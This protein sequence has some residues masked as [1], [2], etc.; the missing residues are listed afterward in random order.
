MFVLDSAQPAPRD[1]APPGSP[2][3]YE[4]D[5][6]SARELCLPAPPRSPSFLTFLCWCGLGDTYG[7]LYPPAPSSGL[8]PNTVLPML[9]KLSQ[10]RPLEGLLVGSCVALRAR[11]WH[12]PTLG[13]HEMP[14]ALRYIS[15]PFWKG[16]GLLG[17]RPAFETTVWLPGVAA[18]T[19]LSLHPG[20]LSRQ[21][22]GVHGSAR[23]RL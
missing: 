18:A 3:V 12:F 10:R 16:P 6:T 22:T 23:T 15:R 11:D 4:G 8:P 9:F 7:T 13:H 14:L 21:H 17:W 5:V 1:D 19:G 2:S 20:C